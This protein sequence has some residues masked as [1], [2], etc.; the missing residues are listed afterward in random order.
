MAD[1]ILAGGAAAITEVN[2]L[3]SQVDAVAKAVGTTGAD[4]FYKAGITQ[5]QALV[6]GIIAALRAAGLLLVNGKVTLPASASAIKSVGRNTATA[7]SSGISSGKNTNSSYNITIN[8]AIDPEGTRR[9]IEK[10]LQNSARR[11]GAVSLVGATL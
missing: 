11:T 5:G 9:A 7:A 6:N 8:G 2:T 3:T 4:A 10:V 1:E